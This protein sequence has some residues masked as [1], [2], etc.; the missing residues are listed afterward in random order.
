LVLRSISWLSHLLLNNLTRILNKLIVLHLITS[1]LILVV[2]SSNSALLWWLLLL[3]STWI[4]SLSPCTFA[5]PLVWQRNILISTIIELS[6]S[7]LSIA[8]C[9]YIRWLL[10]SIIQICQNILIFRSEILAVSHFIVLFLTFNFLSLLSSLNVIVVIQTS[11]RKMFSWRILS[12][13]FCP[14]L[15]GIHKL[16]VLHKLSITVYNSAS[17]VGI[18]LQFNFIIYI[19]RHVLVRLLIGTRFFIWVYL[20]LFFCLISCLICWIQIGLLSMTRI[21]SLLTSGILKSAANLN[22]WIIIHSCVCSTQ[23]LSC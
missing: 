14:R 19:V 22:L 8:W 10:L 21:Q 2:V 6:Y 7:L 12:L 4:L 17:N 23:S 13:L 3:I 9:Y 15:F 18:I 5:F 20:I 16:V 11:S 1:N